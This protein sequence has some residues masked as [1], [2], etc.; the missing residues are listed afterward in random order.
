MQIENCAAGAAATRL[1]C[2]APD[3]DH[4]VFAAGDEFGAV[5]GKGEAG[6]WRDVAG[7]GEELLMILDGP[8][9]DGAVIAGGGQGAAVGSEGGRGDVTAVTAEG[10]DALQV[11]RLPQSHEAVT[12]T[13]GHEPGVGR[14]GEGRDESVMVFGREQSR[15]GGEV[16]APKL[17]GAVGNPDGGQ[18]TPVIGKKLEGGELEGRARVGG[19]GMPGR[20]VPA[21]D[22]SIAQGGRQL[23]AIG[24]NGQFGDSLAGVA[25]NG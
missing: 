19:S 5:R 24:R 23:C 14:K 12:G 3:A 20:G 13:S 16:Q 17:V 1:F 4:A 21:N 2:G 8:K 25:D 10:P 11:L 22:A 9:F 7:H 18:Q 15:S 6:P